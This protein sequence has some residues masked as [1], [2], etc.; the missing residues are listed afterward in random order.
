MS[1]LK[2]L[3][4]NWEGEAPAEPETTANS[5]WFFWDAVLLRC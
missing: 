5:E 3:G 4:K 2:S 1:A